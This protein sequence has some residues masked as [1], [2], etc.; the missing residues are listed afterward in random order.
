MFTL[1]SRTMLAFC[2]GETRHATT[3]EQSAT[4]ERERRR[5]AS[6]GPCRKSA[7]VDDDRERASRALRRLGVL[8]PPALHLR[9]ARR[10]GLARVL[11]RVAR[12]GDMQLVSMLMAV[13]CL[14]PVSTA[15]TA[16]AVGQH[17]CRRLAAR[18]R[19]CAR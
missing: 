9:V 18:S 10:D 3:A 12:D 8:H 19:A 6:R 14:S 4:V 15:S 2:S 1:T 16:A 5:S 17:R 11:E 13:S 7:A